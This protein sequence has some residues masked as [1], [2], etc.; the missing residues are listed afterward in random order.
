MRLASGASAS[1]VLAVLLAACG[2]D[3]EQAEPPLSAATLPGVYVGVFPC[4]G[5]PGIP[6]SI[7]IRADAIYLLEQR[8]S[9]EDA[10]QSIA[11]LG[12]W[13]WSPADATLA[14]DGAG[15]PRV[16]T[17]PDADTLLLQTPSTLEHRVDR[18]AARRWLDVTIPLRG[19]VYPAPGGD[20]FGECVTGMRVPLARNLDY[21]SFARQYRH[22]SGAGRP[23]FVEFDGRFRWHD[24]GSVAAV[25]MERF[26]TIRSGGQ[27][28]TPP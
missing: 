5:C 23:V 20:A 18:D 2:A 17:R 10:P 1:L 24:D 15:P 26:S 4:D 14:L 28:K 6:T 21:P 19:T 9:T 3:D 8:Y 7:W 22:I 12:R 13:S 25:A 27:C 16:F 11:S